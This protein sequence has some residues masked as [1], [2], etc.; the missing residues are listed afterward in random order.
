MVY[1]KRRHVKAKTQSEKEVGDENETKER[2]MD[3]K[4]MKIEAQQK[5]STPSGEKERLGNTHK[6]DTQTPVKKKKKTKQK[7]NQ[8]KEKKQNTHKTI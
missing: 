4:V 5:F 6:K 7:K 2:A 3:K 8:K 1:K